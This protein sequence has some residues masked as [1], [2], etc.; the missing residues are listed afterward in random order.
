MMLVW[1]ISLRNLS[2]FSFGAVLRSF[3]ADDGCTIDDV[4]YDYEFPFVDKLG[5]TVVLFNEDIILELL[6][7]LLIVLLLLL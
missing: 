4:S 2:R 5:S 7:L 1:L 3:T 6:L